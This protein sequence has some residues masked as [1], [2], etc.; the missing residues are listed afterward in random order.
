MDNL[1]NEIM[2]I[3]WSNISSRDKIFLNKSYYLKNNN[4]IDNIIISNRYESYIRDIVRNNYV[5]VFKYM[6][7]RNYNSW[8]KIYNYRYNDTIYSNY[9]FFLLNFS[10]IHN[11]QKCKTLINLQLNLSRLKKDWCKNNRIKYNKW[12]N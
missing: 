4:L 10:N 3:I 12:S 6:L 2:E 11:S 9:I 1:P 8:I 7:Q 5:F